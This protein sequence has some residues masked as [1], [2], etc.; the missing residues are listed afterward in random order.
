MFKNAQRAIK[1]AETTVVSFA[2]VV[3]MSLTS[4]AGGPCKGRGGDTHNVTGGA[5]SWCRWE[6]VERSGR[7]P[8]WKKS[9]DSAKGQYCGEGVGKDLAQARQKAEDDMRAQVARYLKTDVKSIV[10]L[11]ENETSESYRA[12]HELGVDVSVKGMAF[13][14]IYWEERERVGHQH[15]LEIADHDF[16]V[17]VIGTVKR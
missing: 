1:A 2:L 12:R 13:D 10:I 4:C 14:D 16:H 3:G 5:V 17:L 6:I 7:K 8:N 9:V 15:G 11:E